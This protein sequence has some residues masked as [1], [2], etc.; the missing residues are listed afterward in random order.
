MGCVVYK[1]V[2]YCKRFFSFKKTQFGR[3]TRGRSSVLIMG[4]SCVEGAW[5]TIGIG[6][7]SMMGTDRVRVNERSPRPGSRNNVYNTTVLGHRCAYSYCTPSW[8]TL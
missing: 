8:L 1:W 7:G 4:T 2:T 6:E 5:V 3:R